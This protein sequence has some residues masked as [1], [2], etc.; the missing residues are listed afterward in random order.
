M[1]RLQQRFIKSLLPGR[2]I[3]GVLTVH[4]DDLE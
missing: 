2:Y 4:E 1:K 3:D